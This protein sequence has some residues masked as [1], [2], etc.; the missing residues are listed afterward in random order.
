MTYADTRPGGPYFDDLSLGQT[1][2]WAPAMTLSSGLAA[3]HQAIVGDRLRLSLDAQLCAAVVGASAPLAHPGLVCDVAIGQSTLVTQRVK[4]NLFYRGLTFHR[5]PVIGDTVYTRTEVVGLRANTAKPG[6]APTGLAALRMTTVD[7]AD[8]L[9]LDFYRCAML[10]AGPDW[11]PDGAPDD[12]VSTIG[13]GV[14]GPPV[15]PTSGWDAEAFRSRVP[16]PHFD[17]GIAGSVLHST[18][19][20]VSS[21]PELARLTLNI[22]ATHHDSRVG[23][24]RLVYG[25]H[26]IGLAFAQ[27]CRLLPNLVTVLGWEHC[28]HTGPVREGDTLYSELHVESARPTGNGGVLGLRSLVYAAGDADE[29]DRQVLDWRFT[30]LQF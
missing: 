28:D 24:Q 21:A 12:D 7:Q 20:L 19:D 18:A 29:P 17:D 4:A 13:A 5:F 30:A 25:G 11:R 27:A 26:T 15:D 23:G 3:A 2:D 8:R 16:A 22:A 6:R 10:P 1:F 9:V 14:T